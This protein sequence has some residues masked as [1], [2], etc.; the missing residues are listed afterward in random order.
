V[1]G[2]V[3]PFELGQDGVA[4][5]VGQRRLMLPAGVP[6]DRVRLVVT[7]R[8]QALDRLLE[9]AKTRVTP[10]C[11]LLDSCG[12][13]SLQAMGYRA[14]LE[15]KADGLRRAL[16]ELGAAELPV[17]EVA[18]LARP[19]GYRTR[20]LMAAGGRP[21]ELRLGFYR[22]GSMVLVPAEGCP[23]QHPQS[24]A[25]LASVRQVLDAFRVAPS[26][27]PGAGWLHAVG[28]RVDPV[29]GETE[30]ALSASS[31]RAPRDLAAQLASLPTVSGVHLT[32]N[33]ERTSYPM[34]APFRTLTGRPHT[35]F[36]LGGER[37]L[38]SPGTFLQTCAE[39][40]EQ[41]LQ[42]LHALL[43]DRV[44]LLADLYAG[45]GL[46]ALGTRTR[47]RRAV[48]LEAN[49]VAVGDLRRYL[50]HFGLSHVTVLEGR[51]EQRIDE[52][53]QHGPDVVLLDPPR[54]G[55]QPRVI[56]ALLD[57]RPPL[58]LY[59]GCGFEALMAQ[60]RRLVQ[61]GYRV[62]GAAAVDM[63]PHTTQLEL[64]LRFEAAS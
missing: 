39:A 11:P 25:T 16:V 44:D 60:S 47:W 43:P 49:P 64:V 59:V 35:A 7:E 32:V 28:V 9:P 52:A 13:C 36:T 42:C 63:F 56:D 2:E 62:T 53:L 31:P 19:Y 45:A 54:R 22:R 23:V 3:L 58:L 12:G 5:Q 61:G 30:V 18:G 55:C 4:V 10:A 6:G 20:L 17:P 15:A 40:N 48:T 38:I 27:T 14:Q 33:P 41:L 24:L 1:E 21:G 37:I 29:S 26:S 34:E 51:V 50:R 46:L 57:H 8:G